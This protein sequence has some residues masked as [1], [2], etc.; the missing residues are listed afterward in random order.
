MAYIH[1][2]TAKSDSRIEAVNTAITRL[3]EYRTALTI[4]AVTGQI[5][6]RDWRA[7]KVSEQSAQDKDVA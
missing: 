3:Q 6:V 2:V 1:N 7:P 5:D 4:A